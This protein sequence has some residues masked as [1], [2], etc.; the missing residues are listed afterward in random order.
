VSYSYDPNDNAEYDVNESNNEDDNDD[1][2]EPMQS[3]ICSRS[4]DA[5]HEQVSKEKMLAAVA[6]LL[7]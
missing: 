3:T 6:K 1:G 2:I 7:K 4:F 5:L